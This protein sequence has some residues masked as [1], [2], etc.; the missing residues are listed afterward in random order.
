MKHILLSLLFFTP[1]LLHTQPSEPILTLNTGMHT[2]TIRRISTDARGRY[3]LTASD[4]KTAKLWDIGSGVLLRTFRPPIGADNEG[5]LHAG[6]LSP[7][8]RT[9][10]VGGWT[11]KDGLNYNIY[12]FDANTGTMLRRIKG[13]PSVIKDLEFSPDGR[14]LVAAISRSNGIRVYRSSDG[15]LQAQDSD[16]G[17]PCH[18]VAFDHWGIRLATVCY[19]GYL[20]LYDADFKLLKKSKTTGGSQLFSLAFSPDGHLLAVGYED[21]PTV[22]VLD[23]STLTFSYTVDMTGN[24]ENGGLD[25]L[26]FS[27]DGSQLVAGGSYQKYNNDKWWFQ[28]RLWYEQGKGRY[29]DL[30]AGQNSL[31]DTKALPGGGFV[32]AGTFPD[33][34]SIDAAGKRLRYVGSDVLDY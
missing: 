31:I 30:D 18:N 34:G 14:F 7:D 5:Q 29:T 27:A 4:D 8:G 9:V 19:D 33:W 10:A 20:R 21:S 15:G 17:G 3:L 6:A 28:M 22:Q 32:Y 23:A 1:L 16:Y 24:T 25:I 13:L 11:S 26:A 2:A 12:L